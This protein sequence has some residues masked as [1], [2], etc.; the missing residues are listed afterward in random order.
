MTGR[1][2]RIRLSAYCRAFT[3]CT[4]VLIFLALLSALPLGAAGQSKTVLTIYS[5]ERLL[6]A[7]IAVDEALRDSLGRGTNN[8]PTYLSEFLDFSRFSSSNYDRLL[9]DFFRGKYAGQHIDV[10]VASGPLALHFLLRHQADLFTGIPVVLCGV[11]RESIQSQILPPNYVGVP[12]AIEPLPTIELALRLQ[13]DAREIVIVTGASEFDRIWEARLRRDLAHL[14]TSVPIRY[15]SGLPLDDVLRELSR[16]APNT[17][18]FSPGPLRDG[19]GKT[20]IARNAIHRMADASAAPIYGVYSTHVG[21]GIV[22]GYMFTV[23]DVGR[24]AAGLV[25]RVLD[26]EKLSQANMPGAPPLRY[27]FDWNQLQRW[28]IPEKKLP[29][30]S[31]VL[32]RELS[33]WQRYK[34]YIGGGIAIILAQ[35]L[36]IFGLLW[37]RSTKRRVE[38]SLVERLTFEKLVSDLSTTFINLPEEQVDVNIENGLGGI[39]GFLK[40]DRVTLF[41]FSPDRTEMT[42]SF[43]WT[44]GGI[45]PAPALVKAA[46]LPWS[47]GVLLRGEVLLASD[48]S[49]LP[50]EALLEREYFRE[51]GILSA[52]SVPLKVGGEVNGAISF[53]SAKR[54]VSWTED[55]LN[56]VRVLGEVFWNALQRKHSMQALLA[57]QA[58]LRESEADLT[59][60]QRLA[61]VGSWRWDPKTDTVTW[62]EVLY[63]IAGIDP[64]MPAVSYKDHPKLYTAESW[65]RLRAAVEG[66][67]S[68]GTPY[69]LDLEMIRVD[70]ARRWLIARG[71]A[72]R[73]ASG[74]V[75]QLRGTVHDITERKRTEEALRESE[76][77]ERARVKELETLLDAAPITILIAADAECRSITANRTGS[78]LHN[79]QLGA[80]ISRSAI[81]VGHPLPFRILRDG[82][83][84]PTD[85]L[86]LQRAAATGIPVLAEFSTV[87]LEDGTEHH[88]MGNAVPLFGEDGK[89]RG[90][91]GAFV[92]ITER[93]RAEDAL[94]ES[95]VRFRLVADNAPALIWMS[96]TDKL[97]TF[98]NKGWL[99]FTGRPIDFE[100]GNGWAEGVHPED[101]QRCLDTY[102]RAFDARE[103]FTMEYR[104]RRYDGEYRWVLDIGVPRFNEDHSFAGFIGS[105]VDVTDSKLAEEA[106]SNVNR[107]LIEAQERERTRIARELHDDI[108]QRLALLTVELG[109]FDSPHLPADVGIRIGELRIQSSEIAADVQSLSHEL[110]SSKLEYLGIATAMRGFCREF[111]EQQ[112]VEIEFENHDLP[113][114][115]SPDI[116]LCLFRVLQ[117]ALHNSAKH[118]GVRHFEVRLWGTS[119][120]IYLTVSDSGA[121]F[122]VEGAKEGRGLG[123]VS[124]GERVKLLKGTLSIES[125]PKCGTTIRV[126]VPLSSVGHSMRAAG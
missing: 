92:D 9:S 63:R 65:E 89:P 64:S 86:P 40:M 113:S 97:C 66:A 48:L 126:R 78:Q 13:P 104:L 115:L 57:S 25:R 102:V 75:V 21:F 43:S 107:G 41:E 108:A 118:S 50:E 28:H 17:I 110:H 124:M 18:V 122:D 26:G 11:S 125:Q 14:R 58:V 5:D 31:I 90:A 74:D 10:I 76:A 103:K 24:Q 109:Q 62:S 51:M 53:I 38:A 99:D 61:Q 44:G 94:R 84:I 47:R 39:A 116:S 121:G 111:S 60:A 19:A 4:H 119:D 98:F 34:W 106:V 3:A 72:H 59:E 49:D 82:V 30:G 55:L 68:A 67:L 95:E 101:L 71:E 8:P 15:L 85:E 91:V 112:K 54:R 37:Q 73:D 1:P 7:I 56:Q 36:L 100:L 87:V 81:R 114:P 80:N 20:Y 32:Y 88:M 96:G 93:K 45:S 123:L 29:P 35:A 16:L 70:G 105:G 117:E 46:D 22:G 79:V 6:P 33:A 83:E 77:R 12:I 69:E 27:V 120:E 42:A 52:A 23:E 2:D